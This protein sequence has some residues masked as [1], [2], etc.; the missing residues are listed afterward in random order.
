[1]S[2][3]NEEWKKKKLM[4]CKAGLEVLGLNAFCDGKYPFVGPNVSEKKLD[5]Y[6]H[7]IVQR[8]KDIGIRNLGIGAPAARILPPA[9]SKEKADA[10]MI[11]F[12]RNVSHEALKHN[13]N[14]LIESLNPYI[15]NYCNRISEAKELV[16]RVNEPN[17]FILWDQYHSVLAGETEDEVLSEMSYVRHIHISS[18]DF[19]DSTRH[20][21]KRKDQNHLITL[22]DFLNKAGYNNTVSIEADLNEVDKEAADSIRLLRAYLK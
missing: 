10:Q 5:T 6:I 17:L 2:Y 7:K 15:C 14:V 11:S 13:I 3:T 4:I 1:M 12:L 9:Y 22:R 20:F 16:S 8:G 21:I 18:W 19:S